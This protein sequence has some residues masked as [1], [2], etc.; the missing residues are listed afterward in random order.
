M[1]RKHNASK[2]EEDSCKRMDS[3]AHENRP[4]LG[5][6]FSIMKTNTLLKF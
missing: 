5:Q 2:R 4:S 3:Q 1:P 6:K